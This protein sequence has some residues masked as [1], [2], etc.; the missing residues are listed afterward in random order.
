VSPETCAELMK[1]AGATQFDA[2]EDVRE[3]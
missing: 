3:P 1:T 2:A